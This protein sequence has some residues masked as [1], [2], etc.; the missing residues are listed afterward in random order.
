MR[1]EVYPSPPKA[2][3]QSFGYDTGFS[4]HPYPAQLAYQF[5]QLRGSLLINRFGFMVD[6]V[7]HR[8]L[9]YNRLA[10]VAA[11]AVFRHGL[12]LGRQ[13]LRGRQESEKRFHPF[14]P[15]MIVDNKVELLV[16]LNRMLSQIAKDVGAS[17]FAP[18]VSATSFQ[19]FGL[20]VMLR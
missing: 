11:A 8:R 1:R 4:L 3:D 19:G 20:S 17:H 14:I 15:I 2:V 7:S 5:D 10:I 12:V 13:V 9:L 16:H 6:H 18:D